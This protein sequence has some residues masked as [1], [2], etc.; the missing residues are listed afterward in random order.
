MGV[1]QSKPKITIFNPFDFEVSRTI[2]KGDIS[3]IRLVKNKKEH[4][5]SAWKILCKDDVIR[6]NQIKLVKNEILLHASLNYCFISKFLGFSQTKA[7]LYIN[8]ELCSG[9]ELFTFLRKK[10]RFNIEETRFYAAQVLLALKYLRRKG[11]VYRDLKPENIL[12]DR[13]GFI[14]L[15]DFGCAK[16]ID[17][18]KTYSICG[19]PRYMAAEIIKNALI[20][21]GLFFDAEK[22]KIM[23]V[24]DRNQS[25]DGKSKSE[26]NR[27]SP[28]TPITIKAFSNDMTNNQSNFYSLEGTGKTFGIEEEVNIIKD[29]KTINKINSE[30]YDGII[31]DERNNI[32]SNDSKTKQ[33]ISKEGINNNNT[34][35]NLQSTIDSDTNTNANTNN[36]TINSLIGYDYSVDYWSLG[37]LI[38]EMISGIDPFAGNSDR[39]VQEKILKNKVFFNTNFTEDSIELIKGLLTSDPNFRLGSKSIE[40]IFK[41]R[42]FK[43]TDFKLLESKKVVG[44]NKPEKSIEDGNYLSRFDEKERTPKIYESE[45]DPF[46]DWFDD[47]K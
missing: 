8:I 26:P 27:E 42:F 34:K 29:I 6:T 19:T 45:N 16:C 31:D 35:E 41:H 24:I 47:F 17:N 32:D 11:I 20:V 25:P 44:M 3:R 18:N 10:G 15:S 14:K 43:T 39:V 1:S 21:K 37:I 23:R 12:I 9:G 46:I 40:E 33:V 38:F 30:C 7:H 36:I 5:L 13:E 2:G 4:K 28:I 22:G